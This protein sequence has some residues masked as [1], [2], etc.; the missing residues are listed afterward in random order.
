M[1]EETADRAIAPGV[2]YSGYLLADRLSVGNFAE[3]WTALARTGGAPKKVVKIATNEVGARMLHAETSVPE[4]NEIPGVVSLVAHGDQPRPHI[5]MP[6]VGPWTLRDIYEGTAHPKL[7]AKLDRRGERLGRGRGLG[8]HLEKSLRRRIGS[9][10]YIELLAGMPAGRFHRVRLFLAVLATVRRIHRLGMVH[11]D[12]KPENVLIDERTGACQLTDF[13]LA[14]ELQAFRRQQ[15]LDHSMQTTGG[16]V[17]GGTLA[18]LP[19]EGIKGGEPTMA[20]DVYALGVILHEV[21]F[22]RRPDKAAVTDRREAKVPGPLMRVLNRALAYAPAERYPNATELTLALRQALITVEVSEEIRPQ[23]ESGGWGARVLSRVAGMTV[24]LVYV[25]IAL[26]V[27]RGYPMLFFLLMAIVVA[28]WFI[29]EDLQSPLLS[30]RWQDVA[31]HYL[32]ER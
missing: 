29:W 13:G 20:G 19:P 4:R 7:R 17:V 31:G 22:Y 24:L 6:W 27:F 9:R 5:V 8:I 26:A 23:L 1:V 21:L 11:G 32:R 2:G 30:R 14:Q 16:A 12:L 15:R 10:R 28:H 18:Y 25:G 3:V